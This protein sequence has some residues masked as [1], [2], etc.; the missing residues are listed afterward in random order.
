MALP[1]W[2]D[3]P[4]GGVPY[5]DCHHANSAQPGP[6][7]RWPGRSIDKHTRTPNLVKPQR[8]LDAY[9]RRLCELRPLLSYERMVRSAVQNRQAI[10]ARAREPACQHSCRLLRLTCG[11]GKH[12]Y[13]PPSP[14]PLRLCNSD[15]MR[16]PGRALVVMSTCGPAYSHSRFSP[17]SFP[18]F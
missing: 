18:S 11:L 1:S 15:R 14:Y 5:N 4:A 10:P 9:L 6:N 12:A 8:L 2:K 17:S 16:Q 13:P 3:Q 7:W